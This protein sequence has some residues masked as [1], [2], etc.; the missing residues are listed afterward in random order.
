[1]FSLSR[2]ARSRAAAISGADMSIPVQRAEKTFHTFMISIGLVFISII[3]VLNILLNYVVIQPVKNISSI[4][5]DVSMGKLDAPECDARG[6]DEIALLA[7]SIS[8]LRRSLENAMKM[9]NE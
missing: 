6:K 9:L 8:R 1:M 3:V 4:A 5:H 2:S 7:G